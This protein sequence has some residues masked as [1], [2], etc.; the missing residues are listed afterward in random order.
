MKKVPDAILPKLFCLTGAQHIFY[1]EAV[2]KTNISQVEFIGPETF[3]NILGGTEPIQSN[4][5]A[6][7]MELGL[8]SMVLKTTRSQGTLFSQILEMELH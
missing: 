1:R 2:L 6:S 7:I 3:G 4:H 8:L 5:I